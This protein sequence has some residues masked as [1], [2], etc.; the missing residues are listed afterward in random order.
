MRFNIYIYI[1]IGL[2]AVIPRKYGCFKCI[3]VS[4]PKQLPPTVLSREAARFQCEQSLF[5]AR[6]EGDGP[7]ACY[8]DD[9]LLPCSV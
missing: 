7:S 4:D 2:S 3:P 5:C 6:R 8:L 9:D 1:S